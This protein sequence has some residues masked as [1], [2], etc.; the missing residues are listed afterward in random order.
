MTQNI[1][2]TMRERVLA[3][4]RAD[5]PDLPEDT[6]ARIEVTP[7]REAAHGDMATNAALVAAK[8]A[9]RRP[10][11]LRQVWPAGSNQRPSGRQ[12]TICPCGRP[13]PS[14]RPP[15]RSNRTRRLISG[16]SIG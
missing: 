10:R 13:Q 11:P 4:L 1:F 3:A 8:P 7:T 5:L 2:A 15:A 12:R 6:I 9:R 16:Q 14:H